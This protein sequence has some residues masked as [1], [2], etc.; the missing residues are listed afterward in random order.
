MT[1]PEEKPAHSVWLVRILPGPPDEVFAAWTNAESLKQWMCPGSASVPVAELDIRVGG[2]F[3]IVMR[4]QD[5]DYIHTGEYREIDPPHR[6]V[7]TWVSP[8][9]R[10]K[11]TMVTVEFRPHGDEQTELVLIHEQLPDEE[12]TAKHQRGWQ[13]IASKLVSHLSKKE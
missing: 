4:D 5:R 12:S 6:L 13:D 3:T 7:F 2:R 11:P 1:T 9:T 8:A 10:E